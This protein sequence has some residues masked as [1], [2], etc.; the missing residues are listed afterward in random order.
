[1]KELRSAQPSLLRNNTAGSDSNQMP[2]NPVDLNDIQ[3]TKSETKTQ[4]APSSRLPTAEDVSN[5]LASSPAPPQAPRVEQRNMVLAKWYFRT[6]NLL[7]MY[8]S[9]DAEGKMHNLTMFKNDTQ[10]VNAA[11]AEGQNPCQGTE[12]DEAEDQR[13]LATLALDVG[14]LPA[15]QLQIR[16]FDG[17]HV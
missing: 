11:S 14:P 12:C 9:P 6:A 5:G 7:L 3:K 4:L 2:A 15:R 13:Q 1:M 17:H 10:D 8:D 16:R